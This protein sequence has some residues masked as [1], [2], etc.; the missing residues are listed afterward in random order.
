MAMLEYNEILKGKVVLLNGEPYEVLDAHVFRKQ[1][2]KPVNQTKLRHLIT[3]KVTE[4]AFHVSEKI[5]EADLSTK[6]VKFLYKNRGEWWFCDEKNAGDRFELSDETVGEQGKYIKPNTI[7]EALLF[8]DP[9]IDQDEGKIIGLK[10]PIKVELKVTE[11]PPAVKGNT[12]QGGSKLI[13]LETGATINAPLFINE[14]DIVRINTELGQYVE[15]VDK[16]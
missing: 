10:M 15:R 6:N 5:E 3:G 16:K 4:Q 8:D 13:T 9:A 1:Q 12:A 2:R 14:G 7:I 11:A